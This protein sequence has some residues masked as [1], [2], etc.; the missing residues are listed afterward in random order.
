MEGNSSLPNIRDIYI[1]TRQNRDYNVIKH[2][3]GPHKNFAI[4]TKA[5][6]KDHYLDT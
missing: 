2:Y 6:K 5:T 4:G 1:S 3:E